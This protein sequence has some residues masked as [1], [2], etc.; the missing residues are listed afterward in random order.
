MGEL[1]VG[2]ADYFAFC[3]GERPH[4]ARGQKTPAVVYPSAGGGGALIVDKL[5]GEQVTGLSRPRL[6]HDCLCLRQPDGIANE[7]P[8]DQRRGDNK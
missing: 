2:R 4:R 5:G 6:Y 8:I 7:I 1:E 3:N